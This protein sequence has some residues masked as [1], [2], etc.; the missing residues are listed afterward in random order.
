MQIFGVKMQVF[1]CVFLLNRLFSISLDQADT[2]RRMEGS[3]GL[4][5]GRT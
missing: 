5:F 4:T 3:E 2:N 1:L